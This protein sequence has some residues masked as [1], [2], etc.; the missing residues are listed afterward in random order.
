MGRHPRFVLPRRMTA[1]GRRSGPG[2]AGRPCRSRCRGRR[3]RR[4]P[5]TRVGHPSGGRSPSGVSRSRSVA[6]RS[7]VADQ[8]ARHRRARGGLRGAAGAVGP[9]SPSRAGRSWCVWSSRCAGPPTGS[10]ARAR[11]GH[12]PPEPGSD[13]D[14]R[15]P[16]RFHHHRQLGRVTGQIPPQLSRSAGRVKKLRPRHNRVPSGPA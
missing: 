3:T 9:G 11:R 15:V 8:P 1:F 7:G 6:S 16:G 13:R 12:P 5:T 14:P 10:W 2:T 4:G